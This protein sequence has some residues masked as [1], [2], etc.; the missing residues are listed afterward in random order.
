M[1]F[2]NHINSTIVVNNQWLLQVYRRG[3]ISLITINRYSQVYSI[4]FPPTWCCL[5]CFF[6]FPEKKL[7][8]WGIHMNGMIM[9]DFNGYI[10]WIVTTIGLIYEVN[11]CWSFI[12]C[13]SLIWLLQKRWLVRVWCSNL[14]TSSRFKKFLESNFGGACRNA[15]NLEGD[16]RERPEEFHLEFWG[17]YPTW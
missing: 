5:R 4:L 1:A 10:G 12:K 2:T 3:L 14:F 13:F 7:T 6:S 17:L 9:D 16:R 15:F 8:T 11:Q